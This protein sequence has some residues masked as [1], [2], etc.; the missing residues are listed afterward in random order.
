[1]R[2]VALNFSENKLTIS[3]LAELF[4]HEDDLFPSLPASPIEG[5]KAVSS[6]DDVEMR[7][8]KQ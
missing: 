4:P 6:D 1:M 7:E 3:K 2:G 8:P 5:T